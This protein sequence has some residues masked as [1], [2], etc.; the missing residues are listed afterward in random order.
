KQAAP[1]KILSTADSWSADTMK[2]AFLGMTAHWID[3]K[4]AMRSEVVGFKAISGDHSR[5]NLGHYFMGLCN[6]MGIYNASTNAKICSTLEDLHQRRWI[7][8]WSA[9]M[10][11]LLCLEHVVNL[12]NINIMAHITKIMAMETATAIWEYDPDI[13]ANCGFGG[14][15][16]VIATICTLA[17]KIQSSGQRIEYFQNLQL[18]CDIPHPHKIPLHS[19]I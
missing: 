12:A 8:H 1:G 15:L 13:P 9:F 19:N 18:E 11:Q 17:I 4:D 16:D 2:A 14:S 7:S 5:N 3:V 10:N 6:C